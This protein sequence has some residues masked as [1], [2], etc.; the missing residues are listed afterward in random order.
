A[1][2][3][4]R[5]S[6]RSAAKEGGKS[7]AGA[8]EKLARAAAQLRSQI[9]KTAEGLVA[10]SSQ[11]LEKAA[12]VREAVDD[13]LARA[14]APLSDRIDRLVKAERSV[15]DAQAAQERA[16][17]R[18]AAA[19]AMQMADAIRDAQAE[20]ARADVAAQQFAEGKSSSPLESINREQSVAEQAAKLAEAAGKRPEAQRARAA[21]KSD[22][23]TESLQKA[24]RAATRAA[25]STLDGNRPQ[26]GAARAEARQA[27]AQAAEKVG[28][29]ADAASK[30]AIGKPD[31]VAQ[32]QVGEATASAARL[33][34]DEAPAAGQ[35]LAAAGKSSDEALQN[36]QSGN[37]EQAADA[38]EQTAKSLKAA[39]EQ[40]KAAI[41]KLAAD[42]A[43]QLAQLAREADRLAAQAAAVDPAALAA[44]R[45]AQ[46]RA[47][48]AAG[49]NSENSQQASTA[50]GQANK[51]MQRAAATLN[52]RQQRIER[53]R[54]I[55]EAI[56]QMARDQQAAAE[57]IARQS[58]QLTAAGDQDENEVSSDA[59][60]DPDLRKNDDSAP[61]EVP[62]GKSPKGGKRRQAAEHL[63]RAQRDFAQAQRATGEAA[64]E[65][66]NQSQIANRPLREAMELASNLPAENM[67]Q[68][69]GPFSQGSQK[70]NPSSPAA[71]QGR[72]ARQGRGTGS[73]SASSDTRPGHA[74]GGPTPNEKADLGTGFIPN[75]SETTA[76]MMA[77]ADASAQAAAALGHEGGPKIAGDE[78]G[79]FPEPGDGAS[80]EEQVRGEGQGQADGRGKTQKPSEG[81]ASPKSSSG[82]GSKRGDIKINEDLKRGAPQLTG[83]PGQPG[84]SRTPNA[85]PRDSDAS[86]RGL[87]N[88]PWFD[89][90]PPDLRKAI[91]AKAQ[92]PP[93]RSYEE[94]LQKYFESID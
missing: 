30:S 78:Q 34:G 79:R 23:L 89:R 63:A 55:A 39:R 27:L 40:L 92:R 76:E 42:R 24:T 74:G 18:P 28:G 46:S 57:E 13:A 87:G 2:A 58:A 11:Q 16:A 82:G 50:Q 69:T 85:G 15:R 48:Q 32:K 86:T 75:S 66:S 54:A 31:P 33:A 93:P 5:E 12:P 94:K 81:K 73:V 37:S 88:E 38:R 59:G 3:K 77:G 60:A 47:A 43:R 80:S 68:T 19:D 22:P 53:D 21:G 61:H 84:D 70:L 36:A 64:E 17:G 83:D 51:D 72:A 9:D 56:R 4:P 14:E 49:D 29:E 71:E 67:P 7:A 6:S 45:D 44:L 8:A 65:L 10:E 91:R 1:A 20:Q 26:A 41:N 25:K 52:A 35:S 90:L 62:T